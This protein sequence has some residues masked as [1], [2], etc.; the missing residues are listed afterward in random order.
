MTKEIQHS[1]SKAVLVLSPD[2][3]PCIVWELEDTHTLREAERILG[4][5]SILKD[6]KGGHALGVMYRVLKQE[7][8]DQPTSESW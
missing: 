6:N 8:Y 2:N 3:K 5:C 4:M 7:I 1:T